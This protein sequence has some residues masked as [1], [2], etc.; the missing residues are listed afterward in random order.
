MTAV[1]GVTLWPA[2]LEVTLR[3]RVRGHKFWGLKVP[4]SME[5]PSLD[6]KIPEKVMVLEMVLAQA[7]LPTSCL[8]QTRSP[9]FRPSM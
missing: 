2:E 7:Q 4:P 3:F 8:T 9:A 5:M 1:R 6:S